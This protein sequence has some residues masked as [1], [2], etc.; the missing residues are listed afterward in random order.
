[1]GDLFGQTSSWLPISQ[2]IVQGSAID[3]YLYSKY[4]KLISL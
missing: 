4:K 3:P 1:V 2:S